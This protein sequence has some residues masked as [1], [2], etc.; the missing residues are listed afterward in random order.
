MSEE[1]FLYS[2]SGSV[3]WI[4]FNNPAALNAISPDM[5]FLLVELLNRSAKEAR[6]T[7]ITG[8][9]RG[10]CSG[11]NLAA[12]ASE[13]ISGGDVDLGSELERA[14]NPMIL[15]MRD[16]P[17]PIVTAVNG[18][19]AGIGSSIALMGDIIVASD[20][21]YF[22]QAFVNIGLVPDG[23]ATMILPRSV[24]RARA[25]EMCMLGERIPAATALDWGLVNRVVSEEE[26]E[27]TTTDLANRLAAGPTR[28]LGLMRRLVWQSDGSDLQVHLDRERSS[29]RD[30]GKS[31]DFVRGV[32]AF[33]S[34]SKPEFTGK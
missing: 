27:A 1:K 32:T 12:R 8:S 15:A 26:L 31:E 3:A 16:H 17:H 13:G 2:L 28:A 25:M 33:F 10:F 22:L 4:R 29:Q 18:A 5:A 21:A 9:G 30:A 11:A 6:C 14:F 24:G 23:G 20:R 7:V 19:A 34:K